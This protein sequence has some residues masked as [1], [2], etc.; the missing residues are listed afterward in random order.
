MNCLSGGLETT[1]AQMYKKLLSFGTV[2]TYGFI[3]HY[4]MH[5]VPCPE[6][7][8]YAAAKPDTPRPL[9]KYHLTLLHRL[10]M[11]YSIQFYSTSIATF[12]NL[13]DMALEVRSTASDEVNA[14]LAGYHTRVPLPA[15]VVSQQGVAGD[16]EEVAWEGSAEE[17]NAD[18]EDA[19]E[20]N[21][22]EETAEVEIAEEGSAGGSGEGE[23]KIWSTLLTPAPAARAVRRHPHRNG[24]VVALH[25]S[26]LS[27][28]RVPGVH[29][30]F[31]EGRKRDT[32]FY[33]EKWKLTDIAFA[34]MAER[35][36]IKRGGR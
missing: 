32:S 18:E 35:T 7:L 34:A 21:V 30:T 29:T 4:S 5:I 15:V 3:C 36:G 27:R 10:D 23:T 11:T 25:H 16:V 31:A 24:D 19:E 26:G 9:H 2:F 22:D 12:C 8:A 33:S 14:R 28:R 1:G 13:R 17:G 20:E 6:E